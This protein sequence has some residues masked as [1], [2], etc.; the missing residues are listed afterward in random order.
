[1]IQ[2]AMILMQYLHIAEFDT[3][4][5]IIKQI[6]TFPMLLGG[7]SLHLSHLFDY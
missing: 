7:P 3:E 5:P 4:L 6:K 2:L 1:M